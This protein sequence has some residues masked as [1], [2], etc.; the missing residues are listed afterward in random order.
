MGGAN[1][2]GRFGLVTGGAYKIIRRVSF[3]RLPAS[4]FC[5][6]C[7][8]GAALPFFC[9]Q[10]QW[11]ACSKDHKDDGQAAVAHVILL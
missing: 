3:A 6:F 11:A 2:A 8:A 1:E 9:A 10:A 7:Q 5:F 4:R